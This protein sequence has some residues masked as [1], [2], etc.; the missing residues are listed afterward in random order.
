MF[1]SR[2]LVLSFL[3]LGLMP[4]IAH[5]AVADAKSTLPNPVIVLIDM[6]RVLDEIHGS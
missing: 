4:G 5:A 6:Q 3:F 2:R 1:L